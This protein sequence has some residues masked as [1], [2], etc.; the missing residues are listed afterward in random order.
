M[1]LDLNLACQLEAD[2]RGHG[3][4]LLVHKYI[5]NEEAC[6]VKPLSQQLAVVKFQLE[7]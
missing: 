7:L 3:I 5:W 2:S 1:A 4:L 6:P